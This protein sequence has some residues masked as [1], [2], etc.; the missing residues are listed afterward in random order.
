MATVESGISSKLTVTDEDGIAELE[1]PD[2][3]IDFQLADIPLVEAQ[4]S[5]VSFESIPLTPPEREL[6]G[7]FCPVCGS[8]SIVITGTQGNC[9]ECG[10][11]MN[12]SVTTSVQTYPVPVNP[13]DIIVIEKTYSIKRYKDISS[14]IRNRFK[15]LD[16]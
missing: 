9:K 12:Y 7:S 11:L 8:P 16:L 3:V 6:P 5:E 13:K 4:L 1:I 14:D 15:I 2:S 10:V